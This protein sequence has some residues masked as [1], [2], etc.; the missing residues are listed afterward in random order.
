MAGRYKKIIGA[1][2]IV[3][4]L[5]ILTGKKTTLAEKG[6]VDA[7]QDYLAEH[8]IP[9]RSV[10]DS[11]QIIIVELVSQGTGRCTLE[12]VKALQVLNEA[13]QCDEG[14]DGAKGLQVVIYDISDTVIYDVY[15]VRNPRTNEQKGEAYSVV[16]EEILKEK[17]I[18]L[19]NDYPC[20]IKEVTYTEQN[21]GI[22]KLGLEVE[23]AQEDIA[24][25]LDLSVLNDKI[26][27]CFYNDGLSQFIVNMED[28][29][30]ECFSYVI[31]DFWAN[32]CSAWISPDVQGDFTRLVG[33]PEIQ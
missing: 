33:P 8:S 32:E 24:S 23:V 29:N 20:E 22:S 13:L 18:A 10:T 4:V 30:G 12:D 25:M 27:E 21:T 15:T 6:A 7:V 11:E 28:T 26:K 14:L 17:A 19:M 1:L 5:A 9:Y 2:I 16:S 31:V 3:F